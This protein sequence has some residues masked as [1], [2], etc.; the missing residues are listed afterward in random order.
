MSMS[1][2]ASAL[3]VSERM[4]RRLNRV[5]R[6]FGVEH[7]LQDLCEL[8]VRLARDKDWLSCSIIMSEVLWAEKPALL[9][10]VRGTSSQIYWR[11]D[12]SITRAECGSFT[13][14]A[15]LGLCGR[16]WPKW[17]TSSSLVAFNAQLRSQKVN[18][19]SWISKIVI[20]LPLV[21]NRH[22]AK[23]Q[24]TR[25]ELY[26]DVSLWQSSYFSWPTNCVDIPRVQS[27]PLSLPNG[28]TAKSL[29]ECHL[30]GRYRM[31]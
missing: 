25:R 29:L 28:D 30:I 7:C 22:I 19:F 6:H 3:Q 14:G 2:P 4:S 31:V 9:R 15:R 11:E 26:S 23:P 18:I 20:C 21:I 12:I 13:K 8:S 1:M 16:Q 10:A 5:L 27:C 24:D 17:S